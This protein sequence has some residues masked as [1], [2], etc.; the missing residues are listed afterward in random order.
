MI[1]SDDMLLR[2]EKPGRYIG[3]EI[4]MAEK[5]V[6]RISVRFA[7]CFPDVYE[8]GMSH[9]GA[10]IL[11]FYINER[12][13]TYCERV[14]APWPD[15][16]A[17]MRAAGTALFALETGDPVK[18]FDFM[19]FT[20][21]YELSYTNVVNMLD[22]A[23]IPLLAA[24]RG[25]GCPIVC[26]GG[27]CVVNP[28]P[29]ADFI[30]F[31]YIGEGEAGLN[32]ILDFY[33]AHKADGGG[34]RA[35]LRRIARERGVYVPSLY[36]VTYDADGLIESFA[37]I[38]DDIPA[39]IKKCYVKDF[40]V[41]YFPG[42]VLTPLIEIVQDRAVVEI[43]RGCIH[44]CRFCQAGYIYRPVRERGI[45][46]IRSQ[47]EQILSS[48]GHEEISMLSLSA[49]DYSN[50]GGL[51][52]TLAER[53]TPRHINVSLPSLRIDRLSLE[54]MSKAGEIRRS[55]LTFAPEAGS[56]R[57][58]DVINKGITETDILNGA[59]MAF[60]SGWSK[61]KLYFML[62]LPSETDDDVMAIPRLAERVVGQ[63]YSLPKNQRS[64]P[65]NINLSASCFVP[66]PF[67][68]FQW[69]SQDVYGFMEKQ[70]LIKK[71]LT[72]KQIKFNYHD[73]GQSIIEALLARGDRR[74][75]RVLLDVWRRGAK[76]EGW[77][78]FFNYDLWTRAL[79][80]TGLSLDFYTARQRRYDEILPWDHIDINITKMFLIRE[81]EKAKHA[82]VTPNC[83]E[84]CAGCG[85]IKTDR[86][87]ADE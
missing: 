72:K 67:T 17:E 32:D 9:L 73:A 64:Q 22:L 29:L 86:G 34:R 60:E 21:Q 80:N 7:F 68:P 62:G 70:R 66:K 57:M 43:F 59:K 49:S 33:A 40:N 12:E 87:C 37:P 82:E 16:E 55:G 39:R 71:T 77:S 65:L 10:Q 18:V 3:N 69:A 56:Q 28:E 23:G 63:Y 25:E 51:I 6:S 53:L 31:F 74:Q 1:L 15:M 83:R 81:M 24:E 46:A 30:D 26:A 61:I 35:F 52:N 41:S 14:Y 5:D 78:E 75:G 50:C 42:K 8:V 27:P 20:L 54:L 11:Y 85:F 2:A 13:D 84:G 44:G 4:N 48:S 79:E 36:T 47:A 19:G 38:A 76:F 45:E 58:R